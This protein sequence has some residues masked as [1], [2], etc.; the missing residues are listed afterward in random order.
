MEA[1]WILYLF[2]LGD[3]ERGEAGGV[4]AQ[5]MVS[6]TATLAAHDFGVD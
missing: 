6:D 3:E 2:A 5:R 1:R 4:D